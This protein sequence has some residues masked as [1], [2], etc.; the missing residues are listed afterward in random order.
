MFS[1]DLIGKPKVS[2]AHKGDLSPSLTFSVHVASLLKQSVKPF[3]LHIL[4]PSWQINNALS[5]D[6]N[7]PSPAVVHSTPFE[8]VPQ[9]GSF[10]GPTVSCG[11]DDTNTIKVETN[12]AMYFI[13]L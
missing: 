1:F 6:M 7:D 5:G 4:N 13:S 3:V 9:C 10:F 12:T 11:S 8:T 2:E